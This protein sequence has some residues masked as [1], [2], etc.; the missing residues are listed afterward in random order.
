MP[1]RS[2]WPRRVAARALPRAVVRSRARTQE[3]SA[4][5][6]ACEGCGGGSGRR[7]RDR[8]DRRHGSRLERSGLR[9][10]SSPLQGPRGSMPPRS[11]ARDRAGSHS[12]RLGSARARTRRAGFSRARGRIVRRA[13]T[14]PRAEPSASHG[15][16]TVTR[17]AAAPGAGLS[18]SDQA[19]VPLLH[20]VRPTGVDREDPVRAVPVCFASTLNLTPGCVRSGH[21][22]LE[23]RDVL[24]PARYRPGASGGGGIPG[25]RCHPWWLEPHA[26]ERPWPSVSAVGDLLQQEDLM[27]PWPSTNTAATPWDSGL[28]SR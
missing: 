11:G 28:C 14:E 9:W 5:R 8:K 21:T 23:S 13:A 15:T 27:R 26:S 4:P 20:D 25:E 10:T 2:A 3:R 24:A 1:D 19:C 12:A 17:A 22:Y 16:G 7:A 18:D 6:G